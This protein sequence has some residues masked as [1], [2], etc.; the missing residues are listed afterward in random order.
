ME[1]LN[2]FGPL[3]G[4]FEKAGAQIAAVSTDDVAGTAQTFMGEP[5]AQRPF[6]FPI[7]ADPKLTAFTA[8]GAFDEFNDAPIHGVFIFDASGRLRWRHLGLEPFMMAA[9]VLAE[10]ERLR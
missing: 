2:T 8:W 5:G 1:Q 4:Y 9:E 7:L 3:N 10:V 6:P